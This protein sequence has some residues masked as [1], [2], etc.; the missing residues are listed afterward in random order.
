MINKPTGVSKSNAS[1]IDHRLTNSFFN[2]DCFTGIVKTEVFHNFP[3]FLISNEQILE[4]TKN[5]NIH[6]RIINEDC[7]LCFTEILRE[8]DLTYVN[9][10]SDPNQANSYFLRMFTGIYNPALLANK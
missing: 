2:S 10:L 5:V 7:I 1:V 6:K 4:N 8:V 9:S 3:T